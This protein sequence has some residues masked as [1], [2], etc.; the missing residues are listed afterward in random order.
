MNFHTFGYGAFLFVVLFAYQFLRTR[1]D[2]R[3][4]L[5]LAASYLF[6]AG[7]DWRYLLLIAFSTVVDHQVGRFLHVH[8]GARGRRA[9]LGL[10]LVLNLGLLAAFKYAEGAMG[11]LAALPGLAELPRPANGAGFAVPV[12]ISFY[13][14]QTLSYSIDV[15]RRQ[16]EPA[17]N[18]REFA[19]FVA[20]FPQLVAG[21][22]VRAAEFLP[23]LEG[24]AAALGGRDMRAGLY[25]LTMGLFK[26][27]VIADVI[28]R[29]LLAPYLAD[30][31]GHTLGAHWGLS[32]ASAIRTYYDFSGYCDMAIGS[33]LL[34]GFRLP[35]NFDLPYRSLTVREF[36][37][38]W[39]MTL[40]AWLRDYLFQPLTGG[41][42]VE[43]RVTLALFL[44]IVL[45][46]LWHGAALT[47]LAY[48]LVNGAVVA[49][50]WRLEMRYRRRHR[51][52]FA[53]TWLRRMALWLYTFHFVA[54]T[55]LCVH[56]HDLGTLVRGLTDPGNVRTLGD[57]TALGWALVVGAG[58]L[59][60]LPRRAYGWARERYLE[61]P[62]VVCGVLL[63]VV[64]GSVAAL[65]IPSTPY[66]YFQF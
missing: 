43:P 44:T 15:Y 54:I 64:A 59:H 13:T 7:F 23:Q 32:I 36:W 40:Y 18:L 14:F 52:R 26:K 45:I 61:L 39:H 51:R 50:E 4:G 66:I 5:L 47:F 41:R 38:R 55:A 31:G 21:P 19:L 30:F 62:T 8:H 37:T 24:R 63:G 46:G 58:A 10:S 48:G 56:V 27:A 42:L 34:L 60:F 12:G 16:I 22:I 28:F 6:Y 65:R 25:R 57:G 2:A 17:R 35:E 9:A 33:A 53:G 11:A 3:H 1:R 20:F 29:E 49:L